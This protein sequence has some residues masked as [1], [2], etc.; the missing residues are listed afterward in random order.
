MRRYPAPFLVTVL[1]AVAYILSKAFWHVTYI[2]RE[3]IPLSHSGLLVAS[4]HQTY[5]DPIWMCPPLGTRKFSFMAWDQV[6]EWKLIGPLI[7]YLGAFPV[8]PGT[9]GA[10]DAMRDALDALNDGAALIVFPEG[11]R[12]T[13]DGRLRPFKPGIIGIAIHAGVPILPV[14]IIG[15]NR[16]WPRGNKYPRFFRRVRVVYH[17]LIR[18]GNETQLE[19]RKVL[20]LHTENL[21][22]TISSGSTEESFFDKR[23]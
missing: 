10:L 19:H 6:F 18:V 16:I 3:N 2:G 5:L 12:E 20:D 11:E 23:A 17:P 22:Q 9:S 14:T 21:R 15:G 13:A 7:K 4:N 1:R 8:S